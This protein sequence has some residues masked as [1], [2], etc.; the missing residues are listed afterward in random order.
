MAM[1]KI[2]TVDQELNE[3]IA[4]GMSGGA[5]SAVVIAVV[6]VVSG[7]AFV[8]YRIAVR[9]DDPEHRGLLWSTST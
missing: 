5:M 1:V 6:V 8:G 2:K 4:Q 9:K 7:L 3:K